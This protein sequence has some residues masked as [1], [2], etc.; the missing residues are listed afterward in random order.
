MKISMIPCMVLFF[1]CAAIAGEPAPDAGRVRVEWEAVKGAQGYVIEIKN[2]EGKMIHKKNTAANYLMAPLGPGDYRIKI[3]ALNVFMKPDSSTGWIDLVVRKKETGGEL[4]SQTG[5]KEKEKL[6]ENEGLKN[7]QLEE[8][9]KKEEETAKEEAL[10]KEA[11]AKKIAEDARKQKEEEDLAREEAAKKEAERKQQ[12]RSRKDRAAHYPGM[13]GLG[14]LEIAP[15]AG[16][17]FPVARW[18]RHLNPAP[19]GHITIAYG[20]S[21][22]PAVRGVPVLSSFGIAL[23]FGVIPFRGYSGSKAK[24]SILNMTPTAGIFYNFEIATVRKWSFH[25]RPSFL[26]GPSFSILKTREPYSQK[27]RAA[28]FSYDAMLLFRAACD[29]KFFIDAGFGYLSV[30][31]KDQPL[32]SIYPFVQLGICL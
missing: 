14:P 9:K 6:R 32:H 13:L 19:S 17:Q 22:I 31:Y 5:V 1:L 8:Q 7:K 29:G 27:T 24:M 12:E 16:C 18:K 2:S 11:E 15:G 3:S 30:L 21:G 25:I 4:E 26:V 10:R 20:L 23:K 28:N